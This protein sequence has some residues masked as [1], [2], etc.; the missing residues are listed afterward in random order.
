[1]IAK[2]WRKRREA[3]RFARSSR[4][5]VFQWI[6]TTNKWGSAESVSGKGS[7]LVQTEAIRAWLPEIIQELS[8][9][10]VL[11]VPCGDLNWLIPRDL[12]P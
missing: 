10:S 12:P 9:G 6:F 2:W 7:E 4:A 11:D 5:E 1:M 8:I 3:Q